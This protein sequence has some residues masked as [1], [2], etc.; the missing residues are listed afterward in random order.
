MNKLFIDIETVPGP[1]YPTLD[2]VLAPGNY[3]DP[4]KIQAYKKEKLEEVY[5]KQALDSMQGQIL[6][7]A[8]ALDDDPMQSLCMDTFSDGYLLGSFASELLDLPISLDS[9]IW[10]GHNIRTFDLSWLWR[11]ALKHGLYTFAKHI[12]RQKG[13]K[14]IHDT[15]EMWAAD[16][17]DY[18]SLDAIAQF[19]GLPGKDGNGSDVFDM[20]QE[21]RLEDIA[22][23]CREDVELARKVYR[24]ICLD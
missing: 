17:R 18:V 12:P 2:D 20:W 4:A 23:Y 10:V 7:I 13:D 16:Y 19:L 3:K 22:A 24:V 21:R 14:R 6:C 15:L 5:R 8:W 9:L 11:K 1:E